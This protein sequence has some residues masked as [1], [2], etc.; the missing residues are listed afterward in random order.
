V[1]R[2]GIRSRGA[3]DERFRR[4]VARWNLACYQAALNR[5]ALRKEVVQSVIESLTEALHDAPEFRESLTPDALDADL[6]PLVGNPAFEKW[7][8]SVL[9]RRTPHA[10]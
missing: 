1:L 8:S 10:R 2:E 3:V 6:L 9:K 4:A 7:R 5:E